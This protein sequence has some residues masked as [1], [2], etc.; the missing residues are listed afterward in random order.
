[1][2]HL[3]IHKY[4][5]TNSNAFKFNFSKSN[6]LVS[7]I[8]NIFSGMASSLHKVSILPCPYR[9]SP[10]TDVNHFSFIPAQQIYF[11]SASKSTG[12]I[13]DLHSSPVSSIR[14]SRHTRSSFTSGRWLANQ[15]QKHL[16]N[17]LPSPTLHKPIITI[18]ILKKTKTREC[19]LKQYSRPP[20]SSK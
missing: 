6:S 7:N 16:S 20:H 2:I 14:A 4:R 9:I 11:Q 3:T 12:Y 15:A 10:F 18:D 8:W 17:T 13:D 1:M 5:S 19:F